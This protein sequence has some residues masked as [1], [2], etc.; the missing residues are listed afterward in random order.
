MAYSGT[1]SGAALGRRFIRS[2]TVAGSNIDSEAFATFFT[3]CMGVYLAIY[4]L[5]APIR[6]GL[7]LAGKDS[8]IL[9]RDALMVAPLFFLAASQSLRLQLHSGFVVW[10]VIMAFHAMVL[11]GTVGSVTGA[12][13]GAKV[14]MNL[15]FGFFAAGLLISPGPRMTRWMAFLWFT[16]VLGVCLDK[17]GVPF[18]W[19]GIKTV[20]GDLSVDVSKDWEITDPLTRRVAGFTR[21]SIAVAAILPCLTIVLLC[22]MKSETSK[23]VI[24]K[25]LVALLAIGS[26]FMTTQKGSIIALIPIAGI[27]C[28]QPMRQPARLR[29]AF[30]AFLI[31]SIA[32]PLLTLGL[33]MKHGAGVFST[34]SLYLRVA[35]T[36]PDAW[37]WITHHQMLWFGV[38]LGGIGGPQ[39]LYAPD[40]F[41]PSDNIAVLLYG[42]FGIFAILYAGIVCVMALRPVTGSIQRVTPALAILAF[43][44]GYGI[45]LSVI[46]DQSASLFLGAAVG[47]LWRETRNSITP[48][49][50]PCRTV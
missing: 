23:Q 33:H 41:N 4:S 1:L 34:E 15:L 36:W 14:L 39:R 8:L 10:A 13:Y 26:V 49:E 11:V 24:L 29:I 35:Y 6:Y 17:A 21:S 38:G 46:E 30:I 43:A 50:A 31:L 48:V 45:V 42:Y 9:I 3:F 20:I 7:F 47:V 5:E 12:V 44:F 37:K 2:G 16:I 25:G 18:A 22:K 28:I 32:A 40:A 19:T 27:L